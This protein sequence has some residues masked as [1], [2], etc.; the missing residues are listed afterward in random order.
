MK[1]K[2]MH[3]LII[4]ELYYGNFTL[5]SIEIS[6]AQTRLVEKILHLKKRL[7]EKLD[8]KSIRL[9]ADFVDAVVDLNKEKSNIAYNAGLSKG[10]DIAKQNDKKHK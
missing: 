7:E 4:Q 1:S 5:D 10:L 9:L 8:K 6:A 2:A 3:K